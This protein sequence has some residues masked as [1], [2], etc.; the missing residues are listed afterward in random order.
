[1][2]KPMLVFEGGEA[3][4]LDDAA[5][6]AGLAGALR[7]MSFAGMTELSSVSPPSTAT[8]FFRSSSWARAGRSGFCRLSVQLGQSV[9]DGESFG[10]I[11]DPASGKRA[12][13][14]SKTTGIVIGRATEGLITAGDAVIHVASELESPSN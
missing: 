1:M 2:G 12:P 10:T 13:L 3:N 4:R 9:V 5:I 8:Q 7:V 14:K 11:V 6:S